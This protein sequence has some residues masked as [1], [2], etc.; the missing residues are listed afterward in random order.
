MESR[1]ANAEKFFSYTLGRQSC[2]LTTITSSLRKTK[3][4]SFIHKLQKGI[5]PIT[6]NVYETVTIIDRM[7][8]IQKTKKSA[9]TLSELANQLFMTT[10]AIGNIFSE[11][12]LHLINISKI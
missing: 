10:P 6:S 8:M 11:M 5:E 3:E 2:P 9:L 12:M 1:Y 4:V 7:K